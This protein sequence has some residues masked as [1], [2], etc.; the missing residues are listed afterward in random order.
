MFGDPQNFGGLDP[1][2]ELPIRFKQIQQKDLRPF[3]LIFISC[4]IPSILWSL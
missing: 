1:T 2:N 3:G 4:I